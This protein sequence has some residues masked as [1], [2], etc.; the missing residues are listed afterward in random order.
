MTSAKESIIVDG[1]TDYDMGQVNVILNQYGVYL[2]LIFFNNPS[3]L[4]V[5]KAETPVLIIDWHHPAFVLTYDI[6]Y[7]KYVS[8]CKHFS[9]FYFGKAD[10]DGMIF[11]LSAVDWSDLLEGD[12]VDECVQKFYDAIYECFELYVPKYIVKNCTVNC[13]VS[14]V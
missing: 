12:C 9:H 10:V 4:R 11:Q 2:D 3:M 5:S 8:M 13:E 14:L 1:M 6:E 7:F